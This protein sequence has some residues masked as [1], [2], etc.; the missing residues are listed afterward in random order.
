MDKLPDSGLCKQV[1]RFLTFFGANSLTIMLTH[2][3][4]TRHLFPL[5]MKLL[6][7]PELTHYV[8]LQLGVFVLTVL[9]MVPTILFF[10]RFLF[11]L[12]GKP[13]PKKSK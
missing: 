2:Y 12:I 11:F 8:W 5:V 4:I 1:K 13:N 10:N 9:L 3:Y 6:G 7:K